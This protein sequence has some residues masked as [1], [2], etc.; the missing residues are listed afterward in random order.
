MRK[1]MSIYEE[2]TPLM[3]SMKPYGLDINKRIKDLRIKCNR[4]NGKFTQKKVA[5]KLGISLYTYQLI[6]KSMLTIDHDLFMKIKSLFSPIGFM[7]FLQS[8]R[9]AKE[10]STLEVAQALGISEADY[11][12]IERTEIM[13]F[14]QALILCDVLDLHMNIYIFN[15]ITEPQDLESVCNSS[16][17]IVLSSKEDGTQMAWLTNQ[18]VEGFTTETEY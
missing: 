1:V 6:E 2:L 13:N 10:N 7:K 17:L 4:L 18:S 11:I 12:E 3:H 15:P 16:R 5:K 9:I 14:E 8:E